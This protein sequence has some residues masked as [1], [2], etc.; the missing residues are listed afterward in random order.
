[1][2]SD[3]QN[4][5]MEMNWKIT[6]EYKVSNGV[7]LCHYTS[8]ASF[9]NIAQNNKMV[10]WATS[11]HCLNDKSEWIHAQEVYQYVC[12]RLLSSTKI[13]NETYK[14]I[15]NISPDMESVFISRFYNEMEKMDVISGRVEECEKFIVCFS[16]ENDF[17]PMWNYYSQ[18]ESYR[19]CNFGTISDLLQDVY[20]I[21]Y[22]AHTKTKLYK[23]IYD[24]PTKEKI[25]EE[26]ILELTKRIQQE[27][28][29]KTV[30]L[31]LACKLA[32]WSICFKS[33]YF[34]YE[35]EVRLCIDLPLN[36]ADGSDYYAKT[37][38]YRTRNGLITPYIELEMDKSILLG[39]KIGPLACAESDKKLQTR[40]LENM[41][42][43]NG[44]TCSN[45]SYSNAPIRF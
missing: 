14:S 2:N 40:A 36:D 7:P 22:P 10:L 42:K 24:L 3:L 11:I 44:Y 35:K 34:S 18:G 43:K 13:T 21:K 26:V 25:I 23:V 37:V 1:M 28:D 5:I 9:Q 32:E 20:Y 27:E 39:V 17:L 12:K 29:L 38:K 19:G 8:L 45:I 16:E 41:L 30:I 15:V 4:Y 33:P 6:P 31:T